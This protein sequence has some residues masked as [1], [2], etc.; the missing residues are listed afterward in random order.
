MKQR[1]IDYINR[2]GS[3]TTYEA[4]VDLG[5]T[6]LS[7]YIRQIRLERPVL[8]EWVKC[9]NRFGEKTEYKKY[10]FGGFDEINNN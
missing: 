4:F 3:I 7:E 2:F 10:Y 1:I 9:T 6:R 8:D 5:C